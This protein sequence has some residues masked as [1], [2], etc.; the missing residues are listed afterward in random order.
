MTDP[1]YKR[2]MSALLRT[3]RTSGLYAAVLLPAYD[4]P[5]HVGLGE[6]IETQAR[7]T[8]RLSMRMTW[9][10]SNDGLPRFGTRQPV[11]DTA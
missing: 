2:S 1:E 3:T 7:K 8:C 9:Q 6:D 4:D 11:G 5:Q 10:G